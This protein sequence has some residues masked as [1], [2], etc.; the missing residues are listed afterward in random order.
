MMELTSIGD[1]ITLFGIFFAAALIVAAFDGVR[2][3]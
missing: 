3:G 2:G 1:F